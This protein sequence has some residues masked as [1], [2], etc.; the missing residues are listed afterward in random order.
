MKKSYLELP[1]NYKEIR[2][3][4]LKNNKREFIL[5]N[6]GSL[7]LILPFII[8]YMNIEKSLGFEDGLWFSLILILSL[9]SMFV[10]I[11]LHE[12][13]HGLFFKVFGKG[14]LK[15]GFHGFAVSCSMPTNYFNK[16]AY[17]I[18]GLAPLVL[19]SIVT[20]ILSII[21]YNTDYFLLAYVPLAMNFS[22]AIGDMYV[23]IILL[24]SKKTVLVKDYGVGMKFYDID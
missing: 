22:G 1:E 19:I 23:S 13:I 12:L 11:V 5:I 24:K 7:V 6:I 4:D 18:I 16:T 14:K 10:I 21:F 20:G 8:L 17:L 15:F 2:E 9:V 3:V